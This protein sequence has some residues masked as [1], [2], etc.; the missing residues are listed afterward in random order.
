MPEFDRLVAAVAE[1]APDPMKVVKRW[2]D[3]RKKDPEGRRR[4]PLDA[5]VPS[6]CS[7]TWTTELLEVL[8]VL[9]LLRDLE[10]TQR[11]LLEDVLA[12]PVVTVEDLVAEGVLP[13]GSR[14]HPE[15]P[16]H[17]STLFDAS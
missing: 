13:V 14:P 3:R 9:T 11:E 7:P 4:S 10:S 1:Q 12:G 17:A 6:S 15:K 8:N 16:A 5:I 2:F